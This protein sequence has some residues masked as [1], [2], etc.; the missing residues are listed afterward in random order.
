VSELRRASWPLRAVRIVAWSWLAAGFLGAAIL[1]LNAR[2]TVSITRTLTAHARLTFQD[3]ETNVSVFRI[4]MG[5]VALLLGLTVWA[6]LLV[7]ASRGGD[8]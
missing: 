6:V 3:I 1:W 2:E 7:F 5:F 4:S 8:E